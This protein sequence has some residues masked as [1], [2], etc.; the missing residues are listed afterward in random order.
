NSSEN[1]SSPDSSHKQIVFWICVP[2]SVLLF[3]LNVL[4]I[5]GILGNKK[6]HTTTNFFFLSLF[7]ADCFTGAVLPSFPWMSNETNVGFKLCLFLYV[8]PNFFFLSLLFNLVMVHYERYLFIM[9][10]LQYRNFWVHRW[11]P[12][13]LTIVWV[14]PLTYACLPVFGWNNWNATSLNCSSKS[15]FI[16]AYIYLEVYGL[17]VPSILAIIFMMVRVLTVARRQLKNI[18]KLL[19]AVQR[20]GVSETE[21]QMNLKYAKCIAFISLIFLVCW[22]P[23]IIYIQMSLLA[24]DDCIELNTQVMSCI[25]CGSAAALP[26]IL[27]LCNRQYTELWRNAFGKC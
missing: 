3:S 14:L 5:I 10:P 21:Q 20:D 18:T 9:Y 27:G 2:L 8:Y 6:L 11:A 15:V 24:F 19:R 17:V 23:Y 25:G 22:V 1:T 16:P 7:F 4:M 12:L 26:I 13:A